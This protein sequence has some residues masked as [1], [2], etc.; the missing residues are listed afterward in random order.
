[1]KTTQKI[2]ARSLYWLAVTLTCAVIT[3]LW[4]YI[5]GP[6]SHEVAPL[7]Q[8]VSG[9]AKQ[10]FVYRQLVPGMI[11]LL[12]PGPARQVEIP[13]PV[14]HGAVSILAEGQPTNQA[15][16]ALTLDFLFLVLASWAVRWLAMI[17]R[18]NPALADLVGV[19]F[20]V[21]TILFAKF[22]KIYDSP[23][24]ALF[25]LA[26]AIMVAISSGQD[27]R[28]LSRWM[29]YL[30]I[31]T[32]TG[33]NKE[34]AILL[35]IPFLLLFWRRMPFARFYLLLVAQLA[36][37]LVIKIGLAWL[38]YLNDGGIFEIH[39]FYTLYTWSTHPGNLAACLAM[40]LLLGVWIFRNWRQKPLAMRQAML[41]LPP[42]VFLWFF[43]GMPYEL[44]V[45]L[46]LWPVVFLLLLPAS[47]WHLERDP[48][49]VSSYVMGRAG[50][51]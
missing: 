23:A 37:Y 6:T 12:A 32:L 39:L 24:L 3:L 45:F 31:F 8:L 25:T 21:T 30:G 35:I 13:I 10:P 20:P 5:A 14:V 40:F 33:I 47:V 18:L 17:Q 36:I 49:V 7:E 29:I 16:L 22:G 9:Q 38:F 48:A 26:I 42:M 27:N 34:T 50:V 51:D 11:R 28:S 2:T 19:V 4:M 41:I 46:E 15:A 1:M 43:L 44:R